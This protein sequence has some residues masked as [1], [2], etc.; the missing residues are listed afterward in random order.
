MG[1][2]DLKHNGIQRWDRQP[3]R[4]LMTQHAVAFR[5][6]TSGIAI[7]AMMLFGQNDPMHFRNLH[8]ALLTLPWPRGLMH[9]T[10][11]ACADTAGGTNPGS[12]GAMSSSQAT[13]S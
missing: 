6:R 2:A 5:D 3:V 12:I 1:L 4:H 9:H 10:G 13:G 11:P 7:L 8:D